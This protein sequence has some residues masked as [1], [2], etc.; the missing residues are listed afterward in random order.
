MIT[1]KDMKCPYFNP[2]C[3]KCGK[4][5]EHVT[6]LSLLESLEKDVSNKIAMMEVRGRSSDVLWEVLSLIKQY[7]EQLK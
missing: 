3:P 2:D 4:S 7:K 1:K 5:E 6:P